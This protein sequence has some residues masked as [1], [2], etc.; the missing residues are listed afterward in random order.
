VTDDD[1][2]VGG[3]DAL[4]VTLVR[5]LTPEEAAEAIALADFQGFENRL[6]AA[7]WVVA[8]DDY[9]RSQFAT[10]EVQG[11]TFIWEE[12]GW[13]GVAR[14]EGR[15]LGE[16]SELYSMFWNLNAVMTFLAGRDG[17]VI[18]HFDPLFHDDPE[19]ALDIGP[20][21]DAEAGLDWPGAPRTSG[22]ALLSALTGVAP[23][24]PSL[25]DAAGVRFWAHR[26]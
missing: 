2:W 25:L 4:C 12:N 7:N 26:F 13:Q 20:A 3:W 11:W 23:V 1:T 14:E 8:S 5:G 19:P 21:F 10:G 24:D 18:R 17:R 22:L 9:D 6:S 15:L 16:A